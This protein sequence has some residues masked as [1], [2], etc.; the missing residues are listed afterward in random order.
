MAAGIWRDLQGNWVFLAI[1]LL[2]TAWLCLGTHPL[3]AGG[4]LLLAIGRLLWTRCL[5]LIGICGGTCLI[6]ALFCQSQQ[7]PKPAPVPTAP[8]T[9]KILADSLKVNGDFL[10]FV[11]QGQVNGRQ[12]SLAGSYTLKNPQEQ[13]FFKDNTLNLTATIAGALTL[14]KASTNVGEFDSRQYYWQQQRIRY[15][16][17]VSRLLKLTALKQP[18]LF[19]R[20]HQLRRVVEQHVDGLPTPLDVYAKGLVIGKFTGTTAFNEA[21]STLGIIHLFSLSGLHVYVLLAAIFYLGSKLFIPKSYLEWGLLGLLPF[22]ALL[23]GSGT[24]IK[25]A[26]GVAILAIVITKSGLNLGRLDKLSLIFSIQLWENPYLMFSLGGVLCYLLAFALIFNRQVSLIGQ[27]VMLT[28]ASLPCVLYFQFEWHLLSLILNL[29]MIPFFEVIIMPL[30]FFNALLG[31]FIP[32]IVAFS[33]QLLLLVDQGLQGVAGMS[34]FNVTFGKP[35][36]VVVVGLSVL[37][38]ALMNQRQKS[39][40]KPLLRLYLGLLGLTFVAIHFPLTGQVTFIDVGQGDSILITTPF[41]RRVYLIDTGGKLTIPKQPWQ[42]GTIQATV[43]KVTLP[44]LKQQGI[45]HID[46]VFISHQ[47]ADHLGDLADLL[48]GMPVKQIFYAQG[49][50]QN[51]QF[52]RKV[53]DFQKQLKLQPV[54]AGQTVVTPQ[55]RF[56]VVHPFKAGLGSNEDSMALHAKIGGHNWLFTGDLGKTQELAISRHFQ[57]QADFVKLGHHGSKTSSHPAFLKKLRPKLAL[58]SSGRNNR[59]GHPDLQTI[60]TLQALKLPYL[61]TQTSGMITWKYGLFGYSR[62]QVFGL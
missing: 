4:M 28:L 35:P 36:L 21:L 10:T 23:A 40:C 61:D 48:R 14:P 17:Q 41:L 25:R 59:Y 44:F 42:Q 15:Q 7:Y 2:L 39:Q 27:Q 26:V 30:V 29:V 24:G 52:A 13:Q 58:I 49:L 9:I 12:V 45:A 51:P 16:L 60:Q 5:V 38:L 54:L 1:S 11:A 31:Q 55:L 50:M 62:W 57:L 43:N 56:N 19:D 34:G 33:N 47:D 6:F 20:I 8:T 32:P 37:S 3:L 53:Q 46:G 22:Y 18:S